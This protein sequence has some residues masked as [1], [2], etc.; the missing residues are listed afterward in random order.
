[1]TIDIIPPVQSSTIIAA[2]TAAYI[3]K[4]APEIVKAARWL[5]FWNVCIIAAAAF[6]AISTFFAIRYSD[7]LQGLKDD[8]LSDFRTGAQRDIAQANEKAQLAIL[9][10]KQLEASAEEARLKQKEAERVSDELRL[11]IEQEKANRLKIEAQLAPRRL[12]REQIET[13]HA[14]LKHLTPTLLHISW[15]SGNVEA[16]EFANDILQAFANT[17]AKLAISEAVGLSGRGVELSFG[18]RREHDAAILAEALHAAGVPGIALP[19][20]AESSRKPDELILFVLA[21]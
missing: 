15:I 8:E 7:K 6:T 16:A 13:L 17:P 19:I 10:Q 11:K 20:R 9:G 18:V 1:M 21:K 4:S 3:S 12:T 2:L 14:N 5:T